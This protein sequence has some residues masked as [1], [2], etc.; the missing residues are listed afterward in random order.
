MAA[1]A[2]GIDIS[3]NLITHPHVHGTPMV[4]MA[5]EDFMAPVV[6]AGTTMFVTSSAAARHMVWQGSGVILVFGGYG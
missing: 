1:K 5:L 2:G 3:F 4:E 6:T